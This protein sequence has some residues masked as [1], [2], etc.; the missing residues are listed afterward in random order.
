MTSERSSVPAE[1]RV[2]PGASNKQINFLVDLLNSRSIGDDAETA[3][4]DRCERQA[5][6]N[7]ALG[8]RAA[9]EN[10]ITKD[11]ASDFITRLLAA[12][13]KAKAKPAD[14]TISIPEVPE[15]RYAFEIDGV[16]KF[17]RIKHGKNSWTGFTFI[18]AGRGGA[19]DDL[20]WTSVRDA[21]YKRQIV[22]RINTDPKGASERYGQEIGECSHCGRTLTDETSRAIGVG[23][24]CR[25]NSDWY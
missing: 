13:R 4:R 9:T 5:T 22:E 6:A 3:L 2:T 21:A 20:Q 12:P 25:Q 18:D 10:G 17:F 1:F 19:H 23:P 14:P 11:R 7:E 24:V 8:D 16:L 15:G